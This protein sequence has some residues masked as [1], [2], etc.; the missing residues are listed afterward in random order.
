MH[1]ERILK[2]TVLPVFLTLCICSMAWAANN[3]E[4]I[5]VSKDGDSVVVLITTTEAANYNSFVTEETPE[6]IVIDLEGVANEFK[7]REFRDYIC[8]TISSIRTSQYKLEPALTARVVLDIGR[9]ITFSHY[10][11]DNQIMI[12]LPAIAGENDFAYWSASDFNASSTAEAPVESD[13]QTAVPESASLA[14][15]DEPDSAPEVTTAATQIVDTAAASQTAETDDSIR[16]EDS[17]VAVQKEDS[18]VVVQK[19][20]EEQDSADEEA[21]EPADDDTEEAAEE[22]ADYPPATEPIVEPPSGVKLESYTTRTLV[23][24]STGNIRDPF[25]PLIRAGNKQA[26]ENLPVLEN[27]KLVGILEDSRGNKA[28]LE[29]A[30]GDGYILAPNDRVQN[31]Y[32]VTVTDNKAIFQITEYGWTRTVALELELAEIH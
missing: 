12:K 28:L 8:N 14:A 2:N 27:L 9:P 20:E 32:L 23:S 19:D 17:E 29:D 16:N 18:Q 31:G 21:Y 6:R 30:E 15:I 10:A 3:L 11:S 1:M 5:A 4:N 22:T 13:I 26:G 25:L 7:V 24:Y